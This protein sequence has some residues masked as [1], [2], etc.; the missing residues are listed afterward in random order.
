MRAGESRTLMSSF[1]SGLPFGLTLMM[2]EISSSLIKRKR[3]VTKV[4]T[5]ISD[6]LFSE[7]LTSIREL[8]I[9]IDCTELSKEDGFT[10]WRCSAARR[11]HGIVLT[12]NF[13]VLQNGV[14]LLFIT[15]E[16]NIFLRNVVFHIRGFVSPLGLFRLCKKSSVAV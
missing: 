13:Y 9:E 11:M 12:G 8:G 6:R 1:D 5:M 2:N 10:L 7:L 15:G 3:G 4:V 16:K 14:S